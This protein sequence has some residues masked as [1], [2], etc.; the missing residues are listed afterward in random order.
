MLFPQTQFSFGRVITHKDKI[1]TS[2]GTHSDPQ[3]SA[4]E[5][6]LGRAWQSKMGGWWCGSHCLSQT[7]KRTGMFERKKIKHSKTS[8][9][10]FSSVFL[11]EG[12]SSI[13][14][15]DL[16]VWGVNSTKAS[17]S[18]NI[19]TLFKCTLQEGSSIHATT[20]VKRCSSSEANYSPLNQGESYGFENTFSV[21]HYWKGK[22]RSEPHMFQPP[23]DGASL[24]YVGHSALARRAR[25]HG[26][27][28]FLPSRRK[29]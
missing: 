20:S 9:L 23:M 24:H 14:Y 13:L 12:R 25:T 3:T 1:L 4:L 17:Y 22:V 11:G 15:S 29:Q 27:S 16:K 2:Q 6:V 7:P 18:T 19:E 10:V 5:C 8:L 28:L 21:E 26:F